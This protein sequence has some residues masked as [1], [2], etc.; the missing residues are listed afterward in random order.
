MINDNAY[1]RLIEKQ[2]KWI[3]GLPESEYLLP[4]LKLRMTEAEAEFLEKIP[5]MPQTLEQLQPVTGLEPTVLKNLLDDLSRRGLVMNITG[6]KGTKYMLQDAFFWFYRMPGYQGNTDDFNKALSPLLNKYYRESMA[7]DV[8]NHQH[9]GLRTIPIQTGVK[10][11]KTIM[12]FED[13]KSIIDASRFASVSTC[14]CRHRKNLDPDEENC[15]HATRTCLHFDLLGRYLVQNGN[16]EEISKQEA[17]EIAE[18]CADEG[19]VH[20]VSNTVNG[21]DTVCN[22][23]SCCCA[24][25]GVGLIL[26]ETIT[27]G[28]QPSNYIARHDKDKCKK[29]GLCAKRCPM[30]ALTLIQKNAQEKEILFSEERCIG[31]GVCAHK[32]P[33]GALRLERKVREEKYP[34][35]IME[36]IQSMLVDKG[37]A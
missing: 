1:L 12:P 28:H 20:G 16:G 33:T 14:S 34:E 32:C 7:L 9:K 5:F 22:C 15:K 30:K 17:F 36:F 29:C 13:V 27:R 2:R 23:C 11:V 4:L 26:P 24:F 6:S 18:Q 25:I 3:Y 19:L 35:N 31:C 21:I 8:H 37:L 10:D